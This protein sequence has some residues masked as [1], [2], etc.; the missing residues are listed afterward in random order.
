[1]SRAGMSIQDIA[2]RATVRNWWALRYAIILYFT[3]PN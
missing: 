3:R 1:M 2:V